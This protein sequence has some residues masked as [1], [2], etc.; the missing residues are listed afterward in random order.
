M[1]NWLSY[2][3]ISLL[4][5]FSG[6]RKAYFYLVIQ[7]KYPL[8]LK[9]Q[10]EKSFNKKILLTFIIS[11]FILVDF[12]LLIFVQENIA[13]FMALS[14]FSLLYLFVLLSI[15]PIDKFKYKLS[16][17]YI[18][19]YLFIDII[20]A[21]IYILIFALSLG[22]LGL[23]F[24]VFLYINTY[25]LLAVLRY[26][27]YLLY[28]K[29]YF[30]NFNK[31][32]KLFD[33]KKLIIFDDN[34][35]NLILINY[36]KQIT[37]D[38]LFLDLDY[39]TISNFSADI[40]K[41]DLDKYSKIV[42][43]NQVLFK[44]LFLKYKNKTHIVINEKSKLL[45]L[46]FNESDKI[47]DYIFD[48]NKLENNFNLLEQENVLKTYVYNIKN[49]KLVIKAKFVDSINPN[50]LYLS[51]KILNDIKFK[52]FIQEIINPY[53]Y[54]GSC[55]YED[56]ILITNFQYKIKKVS[57]T[58]ILDF[59]DNKIKYEKVLILNQKANDFQ[60]LENNKIGCFFD[61]IYLYNYK[62][63]KQP[64]KEIEQGKKT[65]YLYLNKSY[66]HA[67]I[68]LTKINIKKPFMLIIF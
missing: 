11:F 63:N 1:T 60:T 45:K 42:I 57:K 9:E 4:L 25:E 51:L 29:L 50:L 19:Y 31:K 49:E 38:T 35:Y 46:N 17:I 37:T 23:F 54:F 26:P 53:I 7:E 36:L 48:I 10:L 61:Y 68:E 2:F 64:I 41:I 27:F 40:K 24:G 67:F 16:K 65:K 22:Y 39:Q 33:N 56:D 58:N 34:P 47:L 5:L 44:N 14:A 55:N 43:R 6:L 18:F 30:N 8:N 12:S 20:M 52:I 15:K 62:K 32:D 3:S 21:L 66:E 59:I 28:Q 13:T